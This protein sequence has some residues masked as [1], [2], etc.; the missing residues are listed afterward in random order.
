MTHVFSNKNKT[1]MGA[2][3]L[4]IPFVFISGIIAM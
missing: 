3:R 2:L 4:V 1:I